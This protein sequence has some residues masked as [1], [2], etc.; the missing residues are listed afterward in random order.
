MNKDGPKSHGWPPFPE[1]IN[2]LPSPHREKKKP[3]KVSKLDSEAF[4]SKVTPGT[5]QSQPQPTLPG[6]KKKSKKRGQY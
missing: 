4:G 5:I 3:K 2:E 1:D 6:V